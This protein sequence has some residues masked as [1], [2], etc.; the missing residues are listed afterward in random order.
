M[1]LLPLLPLLS[2]QAWQRMWDIVDDLGFTEQQQYL[3][4]IGCGV[5]KRLISGV[6]QQRQALAARQQELL[7]VNSNGR[8]VDLQEQQACAERLHVAVRKERFLS[9]CWGTYVTS[10]CRCVGWG[11]STCGASTCGLSGW[12]LM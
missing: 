8:S 2:L 12:G 6:M 3:I 10:I 11:S 9:Q 5:F 7:Q 1:F 4:S